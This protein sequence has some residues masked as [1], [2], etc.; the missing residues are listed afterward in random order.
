[1]AKCMKA[2]KGTTVLYVLPNG[3]RKGE[4]RPAMVVNGPFPEGMVN[5]QVFFDHA[6][7]LPRSGG[8]LE[9]EEGEILNGNPTSVHFAEPGEDGKLKPGTWHFKE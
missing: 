8:E 6:N 9:V 5:L 7:D 2:T 1:M 4:T 3:R